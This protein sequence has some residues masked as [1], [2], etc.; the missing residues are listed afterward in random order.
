MRNRSETTFRPVRAGR[1]LTAARLAVIIGL[2]CLVVLLAAKSVSSLGENG[3]VR[4]LLHV[5]EADI[6]AG[7]VITEN[8]CETLPDVR[9]TDDLVVEYDGSADTVMVWAY[10]YHPRRMSVG[11]LGFGIR[12]EGVDVVTTGACAPRAHQDPER[13][14]T[15]AESGAEIAFAWSRPDYPRGQLEPVAWFVI[16]RLDR[17]G[18]FELFEGASPMAGA[19]AD[20]NMPPK[21]DRLWEYGRIG[22]GEVPGGL[23]VPRPDEVPGSWGAVGISAR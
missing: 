9:S 10:L 17:D 2:G 19:V 3:G 15:W 12:F 14:G 23:P 6:P 11:G 20:T 1:P 21:S 5:V 4:M 13:M 7:A 22:F 8:P 16:E 18:F